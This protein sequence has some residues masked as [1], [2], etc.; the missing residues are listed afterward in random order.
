MS[1]APKRGKIRRHR[2]HVKPLLKE[3]NKK[4]RVEFCLFM[5]CYDH[6]DD[7]KFSDMLNVI[8]I[9]EKWFHI[10]KKA[11]KYYLVEDECDPD[12]AVKSKKFLTRNM[13]LAAMARPR[14]D[15]DGNETFSGK[16]GIFPF[17]TE[18]PAK[19]SSVN[20]SAGTLE[21]KPVTSVGK[22]LSRSYLIHKGL[23]AILEKWPADDRNNTIIIQ[24]DNARTHI[25]PTDEEFQLALSRYGL[26]VQLGCQPPNSPGLNIL[27]LGFF[28]A[29][30]ALQHKEAPGNS[31]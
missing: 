30:Q 20:R 22:Y 6:G 4:A 9:D 8:H 24:Q 10:T 28:N 2:K 18:Q 26:N 19:R 3:A 1:K 12:R 21:T 7:P 14:F 29:I 16:I 11:E 15:S 25:D 13:F 17:V 27:D 5:I 23:L 31:G